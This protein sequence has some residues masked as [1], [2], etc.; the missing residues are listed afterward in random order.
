[1]HPRGFRGPTASRPW[2]PTISS[3]HGCLPTNQPTNRCSPVLEP[4]T[5]SLF[6]RLAARNFQALMSKARGEDVGGA[7]L[8]GRELD[9]AGVRLRSDFSRKRSDSARFRW[10]F[11]GLR[12][13]SNV[14]VMPGLKSFVNI[15]GLHM[16]AFGLLVPSR[17]FQVL[18]SGRRATS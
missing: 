6:P 9:G 18:C 16:V 15:L 12:S 3:S 13:G 10:V 11:W 4:L 17:K 1:M 5:D 14:L 7:A 2:G 8:A